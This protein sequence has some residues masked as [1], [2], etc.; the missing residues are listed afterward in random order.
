MAKDPSRHK[1]RHSNVDL[2]AMFHNEVSLLFELRHHN[3]IQLHE[4][5]EDANYFYAVCSSIIFRIYVFIW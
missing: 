4:F 5:Y 3:I 1:R 2:S